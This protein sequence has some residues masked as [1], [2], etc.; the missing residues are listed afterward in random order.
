MAIKQ[1]YHVPV[2]QVEDAI[3]LILATAII[4]ICIVG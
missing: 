2:W 4:I 1:Q 3:L